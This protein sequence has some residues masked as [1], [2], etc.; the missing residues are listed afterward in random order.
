MRVASVPVGD[1]VSSWLIVPFYGGLLKLGLRGCPAKAVGRYAGAWVQ[2]PCPPP[3][4]KDAYSFAN[5][6]IR[7]NGKT[8]DGG[9]DHNHGAIV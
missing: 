1:V 7:Q 3:A 6:V 4:S 8:F 2:I 9:T 5:L